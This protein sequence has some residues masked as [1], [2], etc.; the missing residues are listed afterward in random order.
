MDD[1]R[2]QSLLIRYTYRRCSL[3]RASDTRNSDSLY[4]TSTSVLETARS[5]IGEPV[6]ISCYVLIEEWAISPPKHSKTVGVQERVRHTAHDER[7][8]ST[9]M[10]DVWS[11]CAWCSVRTQIYLLH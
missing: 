8:K 3:V 4:R 9:V 2:G 11:R 10:Y 6:I 1:D 7:L 5:P